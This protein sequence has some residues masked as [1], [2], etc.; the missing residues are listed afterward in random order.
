MASTSRRLV[1]PDGTVYEGE[2]VD[3]E[4]HG[5]GVLQM[6]DSG[7][8]RGQ[9]QHGMHHGKG[10]LTLPTGYVYE[11]Q[12][13]KGKR[14][15]YGVMVDDDDR[16]YDGE[17]IDGRQHGTG[18]MIHRGGE[19]VF[20]GQ[21]RAGVPHGKGMLTRKNGTFVRGVWVDGKKQDG[22]AKQTALRLWRKMPRSPRLI[23]YVLLLIL[24]LAWVHVVLRRYDWYAS[25]YPAVASTAA[26]D[27]MLE[28]LVDL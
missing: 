10:K 4:M 9:W 6:K 26:D 8:Y 14:S 2:L 15:G 19:T 1:L 16:K 24:L 11:G 12:W 7:E 23:E 13:A 5:F 21:W 22:W 27:S 28:D 18:T 17:W 3:G 20:S 25:G